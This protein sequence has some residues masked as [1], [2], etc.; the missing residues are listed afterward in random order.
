MKTNQEFRDECIAQY[1]EENKRSREVINLHFE[2]LCEVAKELSKNKEGTKI[3]VPD[4]YFI[5]H[6]GF[7]S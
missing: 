3:E 6:K 5:F 7:I 2:A 4:G 1:D